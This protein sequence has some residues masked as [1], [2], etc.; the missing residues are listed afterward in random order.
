MPEVDLRGFNFNNG[1]LPVGATQS[2]AEAAAAGTLPAGYTYDPA[3][4]YTRNAF[5]QR[6]WDM[7]DAYNQIRMQGAN[8]WVGL[9]KYIGL[10]ASMFGP[11]IAPQLAPILGVSTN[12]A[13]ALI[14]AS[15]GAISG[16]AQGGLKGALL[17]GL[18]GVAGSQV[19][20]LLDK[21]LGAIGSTISHAG[22]AAGAAGNAA[23]TVGS[24]AGAA[25][26]AAG[27]AAGS[28]LA[29]TLAELVVQGAR[30]AAGL[31]S[32]LGGTVGSALATGINSGAQQPTATNSQQPTGA[33]D[34]PELTVTGAPP[35]SGVDGLLTSTIFP[36]PTKPITWMD[37]LHESRYNQLDKVIKGDPGPDQATLPSVLGDV[38]GSLYD[39]TPP[40]VDLTSYFGDSGQPTQI[41]GGPAP[42]V[43]GVSGGGGQ[44]GAPGVGTGTGKAPD[45]GLASSGGGG[46]GGSGPG[47]G[48][49]PLANIGGGGGAG[50]AAPL[51]A[52]PDIQGALAPDIYPWRRAS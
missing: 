20:S 49:A 38:A 41:G 30:P 44:P 22:D 29:P 34:L 23:S 6:Q 33:T 39:L 21:G 32:G 52:S 45:G 11:G 51:P 9:A 13:K 40:K 31:A 1:G 35:A 28:S 46:R 50:F 42:T 4:G 43:P 10:V 14:A 12:V 26:G 3:T 37:D 17:G 7:A 48:A 2:A 27:A 24:A 16:G 36:A 19:G 15:G 47:G 25:G 5:D 8:P 18:G